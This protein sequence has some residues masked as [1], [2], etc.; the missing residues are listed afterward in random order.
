MELGRLAVGFAV[1]AGDAAAAATA[2]AQAALINFRVGGAAPASGV[3]GLLRSTPS[4]FG[5]ADPVR[6]AF[7]VKIAVPFALPRNASNAAAASDI[8]SVTQLAVSWTAIRASP[9]VGPVG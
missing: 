5:G 8:A 9:A 4:T 2:L 6:S 3:T 1:V 7:A